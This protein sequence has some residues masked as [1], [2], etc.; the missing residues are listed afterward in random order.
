MRR[1]DFLSGLFLMILSVG[2]CWMARRLG[3]GQIHNPG[4][5]LI[6]FGVAAVLFLMSVGLILKSLFEAVKVPPEKGVFERVEWKRAILVLG[7]L[8]GYGVAF[9][10]L[11]FNICTFLLMI[12][13]LGVIGHQKWW[14]TLFISLST[15][16]CTYLIFVVWLECPFP[17]GPFGI[18]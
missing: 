14:L 2:T 9:N 7:S 18:G 5:G 4:P 16:L 3:L 6:P 13:L 10:T 17:K 11:G 1:Y 15:V 8:L 12:F